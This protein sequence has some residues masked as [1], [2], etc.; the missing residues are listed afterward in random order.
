MESKRRGGKPLGKPV[1]ILLLMWLLPGVFVVLVRIAG[2]Y[3]L[4]SVEWTSKAT[5][6]SIAAGLLPA[7]FV[8]WFGWKALEE[9][10]LRDGKRALG[11]L[12]APF[13]VFFFGK[14][15]V[16]IAAPMLFALVAGH[17]VELSFTVASA[18]HWGDRKCRTPVELEGLP[19]L[20]NKV[21]GVREDIRASL[22]PG[23]P[24][25]VTG[26]GTSLG[27]FAESL[28]P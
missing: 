18:D 26:R 21:C 7:A 3:F 15:L 11:V 1:K 24:T 28:R 12:V 17:Q 25:V 27:V 14:N 19:F 23:G 6:L 10:P 2:F 16:S 20:F 4:P 9:I 5:S 22:L 13:F 8:A